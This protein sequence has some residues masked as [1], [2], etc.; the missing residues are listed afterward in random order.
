MSSVR[1]MWFQFFGANSFNQ[2]I[3]NWDTG[4][5]LEMS[6]MFKNAIYLTSLSAIGTLLRDRKIMSHCLFLQPTIGKLGCSRLG[7]HERHVLC[8]LSFN[9]PIFNWTPRRLETWAVYFSM[10]PLSIRIQH[11]GCRHHQLVT[12][13]AS[14]SPTPTR[15]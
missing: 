2:D 14:S 3:S 15:A 7:Q 8:S 1:Y 11:L 12:H 10:L 5:V 4:K 6:G 9:Q 13:G